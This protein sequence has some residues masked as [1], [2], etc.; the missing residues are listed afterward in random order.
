MSCEVEYKF[1]GDAGVFFCVNILS[2][3]SGTG[4]FQPARRAH[5]L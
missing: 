3:L 2:L 4:R 5:D 1:S